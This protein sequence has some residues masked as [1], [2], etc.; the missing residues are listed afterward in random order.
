MAGTAA[1]KTSQALEGHEGPQDP[2]VPARLEGATAKADRDG[3]ENGKEGRSQGEEDERDME[4]ETRE[5]QDLAPAGRERRGQEEIEKA[6]HRRTS[7]SGG[8][9]S[10]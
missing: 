8:N 6:V 7:A 4:V 3:I 10:K 9:G 2:P 5:K 1:R